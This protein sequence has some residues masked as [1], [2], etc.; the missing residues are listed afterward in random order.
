MRLNMKSK[1]KQTIRDLLPP[2]ITRQLQ[3]FTNPNGI[4]FQGPYS[5]WEEALRHSTGYDSADILEKVLATTLLV[6]NGK[7]VYERDSVLFESIQYAWPVTSVLMLAA[8]QNNGR[9]S[10]LDFG[11]S[12]GSSYYQNRKFLDELNDVQWSIVEQHH[13]VEAGRVHIQCE[14]LKFYTDIDSCMKY[15]TPNTVLLS[16]VL[17]CISDP[18]KVLNDVLN[19]GANTI[20]VDRT[21]FSVT[22][23]TDVFKVQHTPASIYMA[24]YPIRYF[25]KEQFIHFFELR[26]YYALE[27]FASLDRLDP[28]ATWEGI[29]FKRRTI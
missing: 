20:V 28:A 2:I 8:A 4:T 26:G 29:V 12:L 24:S 18:Y 25:V 3:K 11:G 19:I 27:S 6:K 23:S 17:Q 9:L 7:A 14:T 16:G 22:S 21:P 1:F 13:F 5:S 10:V 15:E